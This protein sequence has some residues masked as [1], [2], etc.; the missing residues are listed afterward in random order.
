MSADAE[1]DALWDFGDPAGSEERFRR[2]VERARDADE[3]ILAEALTQLARAQGL[4]RRFGEADATIRDAEASLR[5]DDLRGRIRLLLERGRVMNTAGRPGRGADSFRDAWDIAR[6]AGEDALA[7]DAAHM[8]GIVEPADE[9][10]AWNE[11][12]T[13]LALS[14]PDPAARRWVG[15]LANNMG[16]ARHAAGDHDGAIALFEQS[17]DAFLADGRVDRARIARWSIARSRRS[18][19]DVESALRE[20]Q[21]LLGELDALGETDG[22]VDEEIAECLLALGRTEEARPFFARAH[23]E[24]SADAAL[25]TDE[26][27]R[28]SRLSRLA[29]G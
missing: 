20:Q 28:L 23:G 14:S 11:R 25:L 19:G 13:E 22:Y 21:E 26:P 5:P 10:A 9:A 16:W 27:D 7:V 12:A 1:L 24:L 4:Q 15:S 2:V 3:P 6:T 17:R 18:Q 8:L 29:A